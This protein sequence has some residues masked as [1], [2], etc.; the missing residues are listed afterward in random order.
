MANRKGYQYLSV[1]IPEASYGARN[2]AA[3]AGVSLPDVMT[4]KEV[5]EKI[6]TNGKTLTLEPKKQNALLGATV[7]EV[8]MSGS[9]TVLHQEMLKMLVLDTA[10]TSPYTVKVDQAAAYSW[11]LAQYFAIPSGT[12]KCNYVVGCVLKSLKLTGAP[13]TQITYEATFKGKALTSEAAWGVAGYVPTLPADLRP[14]M[15]CKTTLSAFGMTKLESFDL[16][17]T[18]EFVDDKLLIMNSTS[19]QEVV[20]TGTTIDLNIKTPYDTAQTIPAFRDN[21]VS[22][23][24]LALIDAK[25]TPG[26]HTFTMYGQVTDKQLQDPDRTR[27]SNSISVRICGD[28]SNVACSIAHVAG[29]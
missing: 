28:N 14:M 3:V 19:L 10:A 5:P 9:W 17:F 8:T 20:V 6:T 22:A 18:N 1:A 27:Y 16:T 15:F 4:I 29:S 24:V 13:G 26:S 2:T 12:I 23:I 7:V 11:T 25:T 21:T